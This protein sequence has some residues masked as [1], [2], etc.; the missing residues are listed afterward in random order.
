MKRHRRTKKQYQ[1]LFSDPSKLFEGCNVVL[2]PNGT[3]EIWITSKTDGRFGVRLKASHGPAGFGITVTAIGQKMTI[4]DDYGDAPAILGQES[5]EVALT[6]YHDDD[7]S[8]QFKAWYQG[9]A[10][11]PGQKPTA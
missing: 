10:D 8:Q 11:H 5:R 4:A 1:E 2:W 9:K 7:W 3:P 6:Q